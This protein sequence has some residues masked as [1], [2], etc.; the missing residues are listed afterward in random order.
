MAQ[1]AVDNP[2]RPNNQIKR[3]IYNSKKDERQ[4]RIEQEKK[5]LAQMMDF[6]PFGKSGAGAPYRDQSGNIIAARVPYQ[7]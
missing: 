4:A 2:F 5:E 3:T 7:Q 6:N 1:T